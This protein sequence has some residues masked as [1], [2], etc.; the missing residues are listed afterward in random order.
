MAKVLRNKIDQFSLYIMQEL[1]NLIQNA[2]KVSAHF[3]TYYILPA[4]S[5]AC[6]KLINRSIIIKCEVA[7]QILMRFGK[8]V[9]GTLD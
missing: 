5:P 1:I 3:K 7:G 4:V 6:N 9:T 2:A 8:E